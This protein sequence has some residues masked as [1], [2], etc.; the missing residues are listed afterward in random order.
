MKRLL[1]ISLWLTV[2]SITAQ[3]AE[4]IVLQGKI[5]NATDVEGIHI[6]NTSSRYNS[7]T[8]EY[9]NFA[10]TVARGDTLII[11]SVVYIPETIEV[12]DEIFDRGLL[13]VTMTQQI[14]ELDEVMLGTELTGNLKTDIEKIKVE[15]Q[16]NFDD[17]GIPGFKGEAKERFVPVYMAVIPTRVDLE[18]IYKHLS[19]YYKK[20][21]I[22]REW[23][24]QN[25]A[26]SRMINHYGTEFF[27]EAYNIPDNR[28]YDFLLFCIETSTVQ[29]DFKNGNFANVLSVYEEKSKIYLDRFEEK[30]E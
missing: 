21:K 6:L 18:A 28:L 14:N 27:H 20:L 30:G 26:V 9:G 22:R 29:S 7:V 25:I 8:D 1:F 2:C 17:V 15:D 5:T 19:G 23:D 12:T 16:I 24:G 4:K 13:I 11:S 10:I 3:E